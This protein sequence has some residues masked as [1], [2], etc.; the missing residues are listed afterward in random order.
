M[1]LSPARTGV[2]LPLTSFLRHNHA[3]HERVIVLTVEIQDIQD[4][5]S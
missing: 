5:M 1:F 2:P 4:P 3:L